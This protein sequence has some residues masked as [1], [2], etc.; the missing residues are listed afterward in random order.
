MGPNGEDE[1]PVHRIPGV[2]GILLCA[3]RRNTKSEDFAF[4]AATAMV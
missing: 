4:L 2:P 1:S 3:E